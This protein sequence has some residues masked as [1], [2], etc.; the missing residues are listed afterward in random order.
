[1]SQRVAVVIGAAGEGLVGG[2]HDAARVHSMLTQPR[3]GSCSL[4]RSILAVGCDRGNAILEAVQMATSGWD[5]SDQLIFYYS[6]HGRYFNN[7]YH[8]LPGSERLPFDYIPIALASAGVRKAVLILDACESGAALRGVKS[9]L[10]AFTPESLPAGIGLVSSCR[11]DEWSWEHSDTGQ[12][13][14]TALLCDAVESGLDN[15]PT[16]DGLIS[17]EQAVAHVRTQLATIEAYADYA[18][19]PIYDALSAEGPIPLAFNIS[20]STSDRPA[21]ESTSAARVDEASILLD[22]HIHGSKLPVLNAKIDELDWDLVRKYADAANLGLNYD[23]ISNDALADQLG[24]YTM[25]LGGTGVLH[26]AAVLCFARRPDRHFGHAMSRF[27]TFNP[28]TGTPVI[29]TIYGPLTTQLEQLVERTRREAASTIS[30]EDGDPVRNKTVPD[31]VIRE[32]ISNAI[33]HR[34]YDHPGTVTVEVDDR[35]ITIANPGCYP[36]GLSFSD[37]I[38]NP[39]S[40][41]PDPVLANYLYQLL[42]WQGMTQGFSVFADYQREHG[43]YSIVGV[44]DEQI[45]EVKLIVSKPGTLPL[46]GESVSLPGVPWGG[47]ALHDQMSSLNLSEALDLVEIDFAARDSVAEAWQNST[48]RSLSAPIGIGP[49][50]LLRLD[51]TRDGP[52]ALVAGTTGSGK[53]ELLISL[54]AS[55]AATH[56]PQHVNFLLVDYKGGSAFQQLVDIPHCAG[57]VTDLDHWQSRRALTFLISELRRR[58]V[59]LM[60]AQASDLTQM[61]EKDPGKCPPSLL[62]VVDEFAALARDVPEF[63]DGLV[64]IAQRGRSLGFHLILATQRPS[65]VISANIRANTNLRIALRLV[66]EEDSMDV[67]GVQDAA[68]LPAHRPGSAIVRLGPSE[69]ILFQ[70]MYS[71]APLDAS[72]PW[73]RPTELGTLVDTITAAAMVTEGVVSARGFWVDPL[74][75]EVDLISLSRGEYDPVATAGE[76]LIG[77]VDEPEEQRRRPIGFDLQE[78]PLVV[79]GGNRSGKT[80]VL[81]TLALSS[82]V[83]G[84]APTIIGIDGAS[85]ELLELNELA[86]CLEVA[87]LDDEE[88]ISRL[89]AGLTE[90][91]RNRREALGGGRHSSEGFPTVLLLVDEFDRLLKRYESRRNSESWLDSL[92]EIIV[93]GRRVGIGVAVTGDFRITPHRYVGFPD[94]LLILRQADVETASSFG[95]PQESIRRIESDWPPG[96]G[97]TKTGQL[98]Q[99]AS[100]TNPD[101]DAVR[102]ATAVEPTIEVGIGGPL[103]NLVPVLPV[104][105]GTNSIPVGIYDISHAPCEIDLGLSPIAVVG[106]GRSG[107]STLLGILATQSAKAGFHV[108]VLAGQRSPMATAQTKVADGVV[109][110]SNAMHIAEQLG[111]LQASRPPPVVLIDDLDRH[112]A[113]GALDAVV[114]SA[115]DGEIVLGFTSSRR[116]LGAWRALFEDGTLVALGPGA[117]EAAMDLRGVRVS[118]RPG[119]QMPAGRGL[120]IG[121]DR[122]AVFQGSAPEDTARP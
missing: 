99:V 98:V 30:F 103:P 68:R 22:P 83:N 76:V 122:G 4:D 75:S 3:L 100:V 71:G 20:G 101:S 85:S 110:Y 24:L 43:A 84:T 37:L 15:T 108:L 16:P 2:D 89:V 81:K 62:I 7:L 42:G 64:D 102:R 115:L 18:Q 86:S 48:G 67:I 47:S 58:E 34:D 66:G 9:D 70:T 93:E 82:L 29:Q 69:P 14:F 96:R 49:S 73:P 54:L 51:L 52:H 88:A 57:L 120:V 36:R 19:A 23:D 63:I 92:Q 17:V 21:N 50:G 45:E 94:N 60:E 59:I 41:P 25:R 1:M 10:R 5:A 90:M 26:R 32:A 77:L 118:L 112:D 33:A 72:A 40:V 121:R 11:S 91:V 79:A 114:Q 95:L 12:S 105:R 87:P 74:P 38:S 78:G 39:R 116:R 106:D 119:L 117:S 13:V 31:A 104:A 56:S 107:R 27:V 61:R 28:T 65:G 97:L 111:E 109:R 55:L 35:R 8:L 6:G 113:G 44:E 53:S 80:T 46:R